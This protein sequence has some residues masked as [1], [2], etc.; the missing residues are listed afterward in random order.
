MRI[1]EPSTRSVVG[2]EKSGFEDDGNML[3]RSPA[4]RTIPRTVLAT[5]VICLFFAGASA[6]EG[7]DNAPGSGKQS[8]ESAETWRRAAVDSRN[9]G[10]FEAAATALARAE[11]LGLSP[12]SVSLE[13]ARLWTVRG[14]PDAAA[15][16]LR[17]LLAGGFSSV[18]VI[19]ND[20]VLSQLRG[21]AAF[22]AVMAEMEKLA[23]PCAHEER[24]RAFDFWIGEWDVHLANGT[25]A[26]RNTIQSQQQGCVLTENWLSASGGTGQSINFIDGAT[27]EWV[28]VWNDAAG[29][30]IDIRGGITDDG[31]LLEGTI[32]YLGNETTFPFRGLWT[33]MPDGRVR[34]FF[35]QSNDEGTNW[36][37]W[38]EGFYTR[39]ALD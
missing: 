5:V 4:S 27:G 30:Q 11:K 3:N 32:H 6:Q 1:P 20:T 34:Q 36:S 21:A 39:R 28:Q 38:F 8:A 22:E 23:Y 31:M 35:E 29:T 9:S 24:F 18:T 10:N 14:D 2:S 7:A 33:P 16:E 37:P 25:L 19:R 13:K 12:A 26:G 17:A 15:A